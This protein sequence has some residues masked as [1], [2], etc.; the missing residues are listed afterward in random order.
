MKS[1]GE[2]NPPSD[3]HRVQQESEGYWYDNI[4]ANVSQ[5]TLV[6]LSQGHQYGV[7]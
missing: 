7:G 1:D 2:E 3:G 6:P 4:M 5:D